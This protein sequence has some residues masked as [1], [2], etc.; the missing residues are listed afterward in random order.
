MSAEYNI[1]LALENHNS[2]LLKNVLWFMIMGAIFYSY[3]YYY[4]DMNCPLIL[5]GL[6]YLDDG[7]CNQQLNYESCGKS[8]CQLWQ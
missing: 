3:W 6:R 1:T 2:S 5:S 8:K 7:V 4:S